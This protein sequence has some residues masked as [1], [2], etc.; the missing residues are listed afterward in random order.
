MREYTRKII[1]YLESLGAQN[2]RW[3]HHGESHPKVHFLWE[4]TD[5]SIVI[6]GTPSDSV[7]GIHNKKSQIR[8]IL[9][10]VPEHH[11]GERR[12]VHQVIVKPD[13][14]MPTSMTDLPDF[15][16]ALLVR[17]RQMGIVPESA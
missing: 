17:A 13:H 12:V 15:R 5:R 2:V 1:D 7:R 6:A 16:E 11:E 8:R 14:A 4:G 9:G 3:S 10:L